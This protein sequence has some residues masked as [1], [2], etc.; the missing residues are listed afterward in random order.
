MCVVAVSLAGCS[1][2][3]AAQLPS[4]TV[5]PPAIP[6]AGVPA[7]QRALAVRAYA[8]MWQAYAAAARTSDYQS[9]ALPRYAAG[10]ALQVL[11]RA[12]YDA[13]RNGI[14]IQG[15]PVIH[16]AVTVLDQ[17]A[18]PARAVV[19]D[20]VDDSRWLAYGRHGAPVPGAA[21][22]RHRVDATLRLFGRSWKV[23]YFMLQR[24]GT[25]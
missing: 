24:A 19:R 12:L 4:A 18:V 1:G 2:G 9:P 3:P 8:G 6:S 15:Q 20:C 23:T 21:A 14:T 7:T 16:P 10:D 5:P 17:Q 13:R 11:T 22:G 25:C